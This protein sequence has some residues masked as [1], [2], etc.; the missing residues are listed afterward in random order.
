MTY[1]VRHAV[2]RA[3]DKND[4]AFNNANAGLIPIIGPEQMVP[5]RTFF[6][7]KGYD[8]YTPVAVSYMKRANQSANAA[9]FLVLRQYALLDEVDLSLQEKWHIKQTWQSEESKQDW[10]SKREDILPQRIID[11][12]KDLL[13]NPPKEEIW[14]THGLR[15]ACIF[16][17]LEI[18]ENYEEFIMG[19]GE[20]REL[21]EDWQNH[22][23]LRYNTL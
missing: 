18:Y 16:K 17:I 7:E 11:E 2:S 14:V 4:L 19:F 5:A 3:N 6:T 9:G 15:A 21:P 12:T 10:Q 13:R 20:V 22:P 23:N 8:Q 1:I